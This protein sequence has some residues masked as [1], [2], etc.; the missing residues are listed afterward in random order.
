MFRT[1]LATLLKEAD[2]DE[3]VPSWES[4]LP[5]N[6][7]TDE[8]TPSW[9]SLLPGSRPAPVA[10]K[11]PAAPRAPQA[12]AAPR[13]P[14]DLTP[15]EGMSASDV[16][17]SAKEHALEN[18]KEEAASLG[19]A[20][21]H[22]IETGKNL[23]GVGKGFYS[24]VAGSLG[25]ERDPHAEALAD[26]VMEHY[27]QYGSIA[28][29][30]KAIATKP[31]ST[32][33]DLSLPLTL[34]AGAAPAG[35]RA[36]SVLGKLAT[37]TDPVQ[38]S[39][40][41]AKLAG[42][43]VGAVVRQLQGA[44]TGVPAS[45]MKVAS[46]AGSTTDPAAREAFLTHLRGNA[47]A[48]DLAST[49]ETAL[50]DL[51]N[52]KSQE[53]FQTRQGIA[54][55]QTPL[56]F[57]PIDQA[58]ADARKNL[59]IGGQRYGF[60]PAHVVLDAVE[61]NVN[62]LRAQPAALH[63]MENFD[64]LKRSIWDR[65]DQTGNDAAEKALK[66]VYNGVKQAI[67]EGH[68][69]GKQYADLM[70]KYQYGLKELNDIKKS[71]GLLGNAGASSQVAKMLRNYKIGNNRIF[72]QLTSVPSGKNLPYM[73][74]GAALNPWF[75]GGIRGI[76]QALGPLG[77]FLHPVGLPI[78][79]ANV[80]A[81]SPHAMGLVNYA[82]GAAGRY[83]SST[84]ARVAT[85][86][87]ERLGEEP[88]QEAAPSDV[89]RVLRAIK[90]KESGGSY[91]A[92]NP[93]P[94]ST[95]SGAYQFIDSTWQD[96]THRHG[97]GTEYRHAWQA[98]PHVQDAVARKH[99]EDILAQ[100][101][102][103]LSK[104]PTAWY[105]GNPEGRMSPEALARNRGQTAEE[106]NRSLLRFSADGGRIERARGGR[107]GIDHGQRA[108]ALIRAAERARKQEEQVTKPLLN[109]PDETITRALSVANRSI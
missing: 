22:P 67:I 48:V 16:A 30:K 33:M 52:Q 108:D 93:D 41:T 73:L 85:A 19:H 11:A 59:T 99:A 72:D 2:V 28:G 20:V 13:A 46:V 88:T 21:M 63:T 98:P 24:K 38:A 69:L 51:R 106:Y 70:E 92:R 104:I 84:P 82:T 61:Q 105:T 7:V 45:L 8:K 47:N 83:A 79:A 80:I 86:G 39:I 53:F 95:A 10:T 58:I 14:Q 42:K 107:T 109:L 6:A 37:V 96:V 64:T 26:A 17:A 40:A 9:E 18:L 35:S 23:L 56:P 66:G 65:V 3:S 34:G 36:A 77:G 4:L 25:G 100:T 81:A 50:K 90:A 29:I 78:G 89:D 97:I 49:A 101:G 74:A 31:V 76:A 75:P 43:P 94:R 60:D 12:P 62:R 57:A 32:L 71:T 15:Y 68:P 27:G 91:T 103:D 54:A 55:N 1:W 5:G 44:T 102:G 87:L